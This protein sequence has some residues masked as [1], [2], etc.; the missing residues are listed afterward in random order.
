[1]F[2][3]LK[4]LGAERTGDRAAMPHRQRIGLRAILHR[5]LDAGPFSPDEWSLLRPALLRAAGQR[6][7]S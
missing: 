3:A 2:A 6:P 5:L 4:A 1:M 7:A